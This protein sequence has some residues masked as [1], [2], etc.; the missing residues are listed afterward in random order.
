MNTL[1]R[2]ILSP[3]HPKN[4]PAGTEAMPEEN[5]IAAD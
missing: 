1:R 2:P 5:R 4:I 3:S